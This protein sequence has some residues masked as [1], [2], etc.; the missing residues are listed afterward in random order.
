MRVLDRVAHTGLRRQVND[1]VEFLF[2]KQ[3]VHRSTIGKIDA[4]HGEVLVVIE[5]RGAC[6]FEIHVVVVVEVVEADDRI[7]TVQQLL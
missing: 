7:A 4:H 6:L 5:N 3:R 1:P 2:G